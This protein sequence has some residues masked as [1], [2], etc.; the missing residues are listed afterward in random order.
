MP[1]IHVCDRCH[2]LGDTQMC[3][4]CHRYCS[5]E[6]QVQDWRDG[7]KLECPELAKNAEYAKPLR[8]WKL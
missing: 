3:A 8:K 6:C 5:K 4:K 1:Y 7:H 2:K